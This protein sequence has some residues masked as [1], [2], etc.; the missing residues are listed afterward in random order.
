MIDSRLMDSSVWLAYLF[1]GQYTDIID[2]DEI[3]LLSVLSLFEIKRKLTRNG[4]SNIK[5]AKSIDFIKKRSL[6]VPLSAEISEKAVDISIAHNLSAV[7]ALIY[8]TSL[9]HN[10]SMMTLDNDFRGLK[11]VFVLD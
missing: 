4:L 11:D 8:A 3:F 9:L 6:I 7:D 10:A 1:N 5:L 2:S